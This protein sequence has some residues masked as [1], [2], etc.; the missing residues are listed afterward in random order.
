MAKSHKKF[1]VAKVCTFKTHIAHKYNKNIA[2][3]INIFTSFASALNFIQNSSQ[4]QV[5]YNTNIIT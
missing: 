2:N 3:I 1:L 5:K 4:S